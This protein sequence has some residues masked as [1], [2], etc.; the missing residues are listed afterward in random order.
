MEIIRSN[1]G[2]D[3][4]IFQG[5]IY[6]MQVTKPTNI[7]WRCVQRTTGCKGTLT[8]NNDNTDPQPVNRHN[9]DPNPVKVEAVK[10]RAKMKERAQNSLDKPSQ[11]VA[12]CSSQIDVNSRTQLGNDD[13]IK[14]S[15]R[16]HRLDAFPA[17]PGSLRDLVIENE[18]ASTSGPNPQQFLV[19]D[20]GR[21][22]D[23]RVIVFGSPDALRHLSIAET[24]FMDG[25][26]DVAPE[27]FCQLYVIRCPLGN[28]AVSCA[29]ALLQ[30]KS[31]E[32]YEQLLYPKLENGDITS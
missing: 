27:G 12:Q 15:I 20:N 13:S 21:D 23:S 22:S 17:V 29:Y 24:W 18:W 2:G 30:R 14:R 3:K 19:Y 26:F 4:L 1:K 10:C 31:Q 11:I 6:T 9:H 28:T 8:T 5:Y 25:N 7:R 32:A 16:N